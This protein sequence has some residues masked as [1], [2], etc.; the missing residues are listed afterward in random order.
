[1]GLIQVWAS[2]VNSIRTHIGITQLRQYDDEYDNEISVL[3]V[4]N[5]LRINSI[6]LRFR[7]W[8]LACRYRNWSGCFVRAICIREINLGA[9]SSIDLYEQVEKFY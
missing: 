3:F 4:L 7:L 8:A 9:D 1:M 5:F 6:S 2:Y